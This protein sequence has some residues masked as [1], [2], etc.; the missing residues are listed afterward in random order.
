M[1][2]HEH[3]SLVSIMTSKVKFRIK[4]SLE[5]LC[6]VEVHVLRPAFSFCRI[7]KVKVHGMVS[8]M[9]TRVDTMNHVIVKRFVIGRSSGLPTT[10]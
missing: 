10:R 1:Y 2:A 7:S 9:E 6:D 5:E 4:P 8:A 3:K